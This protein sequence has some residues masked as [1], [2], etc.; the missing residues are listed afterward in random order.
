LVPSHVINFD[1]ETE[2][3]DIELKSITGKKHAFS[4]ESWLS[5][6]SI[7]CATSEDDKNDWL[8]SCDK[9]KMAMEKPDKK[10][11]RKYDYD[12]FLSHRQATGADLAMSIKV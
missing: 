12:L 8:A 3:F 4:I 9:A 1:K 11:Q 7:F 6:N 5:G 10:V 2:F